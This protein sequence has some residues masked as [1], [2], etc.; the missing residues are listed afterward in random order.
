MGVGRKTQQ[1]QM[2]VAS[3]FQRE[4]ARRGLSPPTFDNW[5]KGRSNIVPS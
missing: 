2:R 4:S 3:E 1:R 5:P